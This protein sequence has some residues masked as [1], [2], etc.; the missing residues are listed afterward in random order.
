MAESN[1][2]LL[3]EVLAGQAAFAARFEDLVNR[4]D[5][6]ATDAREARDL[7][8]RITTILKEQDIVA[9][10]AELRG[11]TRQV[12]SEIRQD[13]VAAN[14]RLREDLAIETRERKACHAELE[15]RLESLEEQRNKVVG[16]ASFFGWLAKSAPWLLAGMAAFVA[17][18]GIKDKIP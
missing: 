7:G 9:R 6:T 5:A 3:R 1:E 18:L 17:G 14:I 13:F 2:S 16:V 12:V 15:K 10:L 11:E 4:L 8:N